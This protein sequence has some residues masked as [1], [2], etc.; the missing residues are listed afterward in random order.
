VQLGAA[1]VAVPLF[2]R[3]GLGSVLGYLAAGIAIGPFG[4]GVF[5][6]PESI[7]HVAEIG[8]VLFL[9]IIGL[10]MQPSRLWSMRGEIF[11][12]GFAQLGLCVLLLSTVG[13]ALGY[14]FTQSLIAGAGF[15]LTSTAV[16]MQMLEERHALNLP[17]GR[18]MVAILLLEDLAI[19]PL[20]ALVTFLAPGGPEVTLGQRFIDVGIGLGAI[21]LL[22][23]AGRYLLDPMFRIL[24]NS[25]AREVM[26]AAALLVVLGAALGLQ[27]GGLSMAM[28]AFLAGV[29]LSESSFRHQL[30]A[31]I[32]PFRGLLLGLFFLSVGMTL[33]LSVLA[34]E[35]RLVA[36]AVV[37]YM[38]LKMAGIYVVARLFHADHRES[39]QRAVVMAQGGEFAFV[40]Y[41]AAVT[42]GLIDGRS[43]A[44]LTATIILSMAITPLA[45]LLHDRLVSRPRPSM[46]GLE[47]PD[48]LSAN[49]LLIGFGRFGQI[50]SQ[51][52]LA[53]GYSISMIE[54]DADFIRQAAE[55]GFKVHYGDGTR[56][57]ILHAA[58]AH[59]ARLI[60]IAVDERDAILKIAKLAKA[61]FPLVP[62][63]ARAYDRVHASELIH[64]GVTWQIRETFESAVLLGMH[65]LE[66][67]GVPEQE[68]ATVLEDFRRRDAE[69]LALEVAGGIYA[70]RDLIFVNAPRREPKAGD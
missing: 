42:A 68:R 48:H 24:G 26:T 69:R 35:W 13:L 5:A 14:P 8:V 57:D 62:V 28:G 23:L 7:L 21:L 59:E 70:G 65:A 54:T 58:G 34:A 67:L 50:V 31:D 9:F 4:F 30:E 44:V 36:I 10:E 38:T 51:P 11:G 47:V 33:D 40:L 12:L 25:R 55:F 16:V 2:R 60:V 15:V 56:L 29:L 3:L 46:E 52:L 20:L 17:P 39:L 27:L 37:A 45:V 22:V 64:A 66:V 53:R 49:V 1:V 61:E 43:N 19:V 18:R 41:T 32:E 63:L 6:H